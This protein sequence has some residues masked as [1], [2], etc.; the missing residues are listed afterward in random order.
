MPNGLKLVASV[1]NWWKAP[2]FISLSQIA[3][4]NPKGPYTL[5]TKLQRLLKTIAENL[6]ARIK[7]LLKKSLQL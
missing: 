4:L 6:F 3:S 7:E 5:H 2:F 1:I